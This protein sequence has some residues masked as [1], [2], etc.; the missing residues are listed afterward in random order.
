[1]KSTAC[2]LM[3]GR[4][5]SPPTNHGQRRHWS[6]TDDALR[7]AL[8]RYGWPLISDPHAAI[9]D[10]YVTLVAY[11]EIP[12]MLEGLAPWPGV[13]LSNGAPHMLEAVVAS[14]GL[15]GKFTHILGADLVKVYQPNP[16]E[17]ALASQILGL[18]KEAMVFVSSNSFE[19]PGAKMYGF[20]VVWINRAG[21]QADKL[22]MAP[23][24]V[25]SRLEQLPEAFPAMSRQLYGRLDH[26]RQE[27]RA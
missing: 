12:I 15:P 24:R 14:S 4:K 18:P 27:E 21:T 2:L 16:R 26:E 10:A 8:K 11:P 1:M 6:V 22:G 23:D 3:Q 13:T 9:L 19:V 17:Y 25:L 5:G 20:Q 7:F